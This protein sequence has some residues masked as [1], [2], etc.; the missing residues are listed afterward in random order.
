MGRHDAVL[1]VVP[2]LR[3]PSPGTCRVRPSPNGGCRSPNG[4]C[5]SPSGAPWK[6]QWGAIGPLVGIGD[7]WGHAGCGLASWKPGQTCLEKSCLQVRPASPSSPKALPGIEDRHWRSV[8]RDESRPR[9][10]QSAAHQAQH[11]RRFAAR[12]FS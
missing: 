1:D 12:R 2:C 9:S 7:K 8:T 3:K 10:P 6:P 4:G 5:R 11:S